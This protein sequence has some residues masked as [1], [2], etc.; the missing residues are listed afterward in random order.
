MS[1]VRREAVPGRRKRRPR[2]EAAE[3]LG[4]QQHLGAD[5]AAALSLHRQGQQPHQAQGQQAIEIRC[6][7]LEFKTP[8]ALHLAALPEYKGAPTRAK[9]RLEGGLGDL[10]TSVPL[11]PARHG[12]QTGEALTSAPRCAHRTGLSLLHKST[13]SNTRLSSPT[14]TVTLPETAA[15][16]RSEATEEAFN[17]G[18]LTESSAAISPS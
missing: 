14:R 18:L 7:T 17:S 10:W 1:P 8:H 4:G 5:R 15:R 12:S 6:E 16:Q 9:L 13:T 3:R 2:G 11:W